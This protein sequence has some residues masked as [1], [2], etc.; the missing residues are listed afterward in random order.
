MQIFIMR[1]GEAALDAASDALR[2]L[3]ER[4]KNE[5]TKMAKWMTK[6][7]SNIDYVLVSPYLR[8]QQTLDE[9]GKTLPL[10]SKIETENGL[11][12]NGDATHIA[13]YLQVLGDLGYQNILV[14]SHLPLVGYV[15]ASLCP[16]IPAPMFSTS[17]IACV[18]F[19]VSKG[20]G[21]L[22]W[23]ISPSELEE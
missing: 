17:T 3:T 19:S 6:Q 14:V 16:S 9:V 18:D 22:L 23:Q 2:P 10:P 13:H 5:S 15:V 20:T 12:P 11:T 1:H 21:E 7:G 8:A 4:G